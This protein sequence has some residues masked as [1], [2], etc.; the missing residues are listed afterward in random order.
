MIFDFQLPD[1]IETARAAAPAA[2]TPLPRQR[3]R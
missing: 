2:C 1:L 3:V